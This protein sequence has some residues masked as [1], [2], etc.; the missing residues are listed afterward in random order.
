MS[1]MNVSLHHF[2]DMKINLGL[3]VAEID[4][5]FNLNSLKPMS[6]TYRVKNSYKTLKLGDHYYQIGGTI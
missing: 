5:G 6:I 4:I 3:M 2:H 1:K